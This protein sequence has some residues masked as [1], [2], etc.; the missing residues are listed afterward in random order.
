MK[1]KQF[2][3]LLMAGVIVTFTSCS[4]NTDTSVAE[5]QVF[6]LTLNLSDEVKSRA[7]FDENA[8][9]SDLR[10]CI[11]VS[12][13]GKV[14][15]SFTETGWDGTTKSIDFRLVT[16]EEYTISAWADYG[17]DYYTVNG[18]V[19]SAPSVE[20]ADASNV[21]G[22]DNK[23]DAFYAIT[24]VTFT[25]TDS[26]TEM[27]LTRPFAL[28]L[29]NTNDL[30]EPA[31]VNADLVP[32][33]YKG[34]F[35]APT[36]LNLITGETGDAEEVISYGECNGAELSYDFIF[37]TTDEIVLHTFTCSYYAGETLV[38]DFTFN[39]IPV[40]CNYITDINGNILTKSGTAT[41]E[42]NDEW[43]GIYE[44]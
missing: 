18:T 24:A 16:N 5:E 20:M 43:D 23:A 34:V 40:R 17:S 36:S 28:V 8:T 6:S 3:Y 12:Y 4:K 13:D 38:S 7:A 39:S 11:L 37:T 31:L 19:G 2:F 9:L 35:Y 10:L 21:K 41:F 22:A 33:T 15:D 42:I 14:V 27:T 25:G 32:T 29:I 44:N 30:E 1:L 26:S